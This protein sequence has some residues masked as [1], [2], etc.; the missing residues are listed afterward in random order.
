MTTMMYRMS[1]TIGRN[2]PIEE[3]E[4]VIKRCDIVQRFIIEKNYVDKIGNTMLKY[5]YN[6]TK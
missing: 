5:K 6:S 1:T 2:N 4:K 3:N